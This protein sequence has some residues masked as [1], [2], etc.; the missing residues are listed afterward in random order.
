MQFK[1]V[2]SA[3]YSSR[4]DEAGSIIEYSKKII[5]AGTDQLNVQEQLESKKLM[6]L[7]LYSIA[8]FPTKK[9]LKV[10]GKILGKKVIVLIDSGAS[11]NSIS[12]AVAEELSLKQTETKPFVMEVGNGQQIKSRGRC[13]EVELW[14]DKLQI[15]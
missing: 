8:G 3:Y 13:K 11:T 4:G 6:E 10:W 2:K 9:S 12:R 14:I 7:S 1:T 15:T 5:N